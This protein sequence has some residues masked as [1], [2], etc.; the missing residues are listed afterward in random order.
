MHPEMHGL[1]FKNQVFLAGFPQF[2]TSMF[3]NK[4][5]GYSSS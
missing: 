5:L 1:T 4:H 3:F 2:S